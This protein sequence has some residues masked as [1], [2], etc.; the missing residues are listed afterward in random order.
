MLLDELKVPFRWYDDSARRIGK[1]S[2][3][4][5]YR[6]RLITPFDRLLPFMYRFKTLG[7]P[8]FPVSWKLYKTSDDSLVATLDLNFLHYY[9]FGTYDYIIYKGDPLD[10]A[11]APGFYYSIIDLDG[12]GPTLYSEDFYVDCDADGR[13]IGGDF[14]DDF[15]E[16]F[17]P[18]ITV[19]G[20]LKKYTKLEWWND[21]DLG[22]ILYQTG[23]HNILFFDVDLIR[24]TPEILEEGTENGLKDFIPT[25]RKYIDKI[26]FDDYVPEYIL[27]ALL[28]VRLHKEVVCTTKENLYT[29]KARQFNV[30]HTFQNSCY[31]SI[32]CTFQQET[33]FLKANCCNNNTITDYYSCPFAYDN[34]L[35]NEI[36]CNESACDLEFNFSSSGLLPAGLWWQFGITPTGGSET[37]SETQDATFT[38]GPFLHCQ[39]ITI[40]IRSKCTAANGVVSYGQWFTNVY[41]IGANPRF[42]QITNNTPNQLDFTYI[43]RHCEPQAGLV[44]AGVDFITTC[45]ASGSFAT[46]AAPADY[47]IAD[48]SSCPPE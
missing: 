20:S 26:R 10:I 9:N 16:D 22:N 40:R 32:V 15:N 43:D 4:D 7:T 1:I 38:A 14:N 23:Y 41:K 29:G 3:C 46:N 28:L 42:Y 11:M 48:V 21:C 37:L 35:V 25:F 36:N 17:G 6:Y 39:E 34:L 24:D 13:Q 19:G 5:G 44:G 45:M 8:T 12:D 27:S 18:L 33:T 31:A 30:E 2:E 47:A